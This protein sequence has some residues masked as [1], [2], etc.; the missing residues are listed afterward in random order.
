MKQSDPALMT[1]WARYCESQGAWSKA[2]L[3]YQRT[4]GQRGATARGI[5]PPD[6]RA[7]GPAAPAGF[8]LLGNG[9][10]KANVLIKMHV[11]VIS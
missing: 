10:N 4:G 9:T 5:D 11:Q 7:W 6:C 3:C 2:L 8:G 1:W